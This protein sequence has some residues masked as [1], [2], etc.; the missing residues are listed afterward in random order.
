MRVEELPNFSQLYDEVF[1]CPFCDARFIRSRDRDTD[2]DVAT[3]EEKWKAGRRES[4][5]DHLVRSPQ[6]T[7][8]TV[9]E[10]D[11]N[12]GLVGVYRCHA[13]L[14]PG[15]PIAL[16][17]GTTYVISDAYV[18]HTLSAGEPIGQISIHCKRSD[19]AANALGVI[20]LST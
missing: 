3:T 10:G 18:N 1:P 5:A 15:R 4:V 8:V 13:E 6:P 9:Y 16:P 20:R 12:T 17:S 2:R 11:D 7:G 19:V 14:K